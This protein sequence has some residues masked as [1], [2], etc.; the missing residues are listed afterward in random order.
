[1][2][3][4][5]LAAKSRLPAPADG[6]ASGVLVAGPRQSGLTALSSTL[7]AR[8]A[9][10]R[11]TALSAEVNARP[12]VSQQA[13]WES[14]G[15][16]ASDQ[17]GLPPK[18]RAGV[19][20]LSGVSM[21]GVRVHRNSSKP[22]QMR[23]HAF[24]QGREIH[25]APGQDRHLPH[26]AWHVVQQA[27]GRVRPSRQMMGN[28][29]V[30]DEA[31]L[32]SE[33]TTMGARALQCAGLAETPSAVG[34]TAAGGVVQRAKY[35]WVGDRWEHDGGASSSTAKA[36]KAVGDFMGQVFDDDDGSYTSAEVLEE[37]AT[38]H[39]L[40]LGQH[41]ALDEQDGKE[42]EED[43]PRAF[44]PRDYIP[45][46]QLEVP[47]NI[48]FIWSG[49]AISDAALGN[50]RIWGELA[51]KAKG[52]RVS[53][54]TDK[55]DSNWGMLVRSKLFLSGVSLEYI[56]KDTL[57]PSLWPSYDGLIHGKD[58]NYPAASDL[59]RY[60]ILKRHGGVYCD[61]DIGP[62]MAALEDIGR[63]SPILPRL[64]P[65][66]RDA[67]AVRDELGKGHDAP[68]SSQDIQ[69]AAGRRMEKGQFNNNFIVA[70]RNAPALDTIIITVLKKLEQAGGPKGLLREQQ[71]MAAFVT[72]PQAVTE[73]LRLFVE[74]N[75]DLDS[76]KALAVVKAIV[77]HDLPLDWVTP[78]S[79][80]QE[81]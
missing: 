18:L 47:K 34:A 45:P 53:V 27:Q 48:H 8:P 77:A 32:E 41:R 17:T 36:P 39:P 56:V 71:D 25:I 33:A 62:G 30:N 46:E 65:E 28:V 26:E 81:H 21:D 11:L 78:E 22:A 6:T 55:V 76:A 42:R 14:A 54:W 40:T 43:R 79:E 44:N 80:A 51:K 9:V 13:A 50:I 2:R 74:Q 15:P 72:G 4:S 59:A 60:S 12:A 75:F 5:S 23:A 7:N 52:W 31:R 69:I 3:S 19:E 20:S 24:A 58:K 73:G 67:T 1:M 70:D 35:T 29:Q 37:D 68:I 66:L 63:V 64:A 38:E 57:D 16:R 10:A 61:V 49:R